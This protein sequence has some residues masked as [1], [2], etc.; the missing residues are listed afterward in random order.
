MNTNGYE[1]SFWGD[2]SSGIRHCKIFC[3]NSVKNAIGSLI[4]ITLNL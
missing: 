3:S 4:G 2:E 1:F